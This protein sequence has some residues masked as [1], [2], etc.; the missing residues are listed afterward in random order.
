MIAL[1]T[2]S[3]AILLYFRAKSKGFPQEDALNALIY[4]VLGMAV[5]SKLLYIV[6]Y[7]PQ[8][9]SQLDTIKADPL[10]LIE[11]LSSGFVFYGGLI[12]GIGAVLA[13]AH[14]YQVPKL[15]LVNVLTPVIPFIHG[16]GRIGCFLA[17][18]C[19]GIP[20][21]GPLSVVYTQSIAAPRNIAMFPVQLLESLLLFLLAFFLLSYDR[22]AKNPRNLGGWYLLL[23]GVIRL[24]TELF[25]GDISRGFFMMLSTSQWISLMM[26]AVAAVL[27]YKKP[28]LLSTDQTV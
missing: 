12:G 27:L 6:Q 25:R 8:I 19:Y 10:S 17:G 2:L 16:F 21:D 13:Y 26:I 24:V 5:G 18:C 11:L 4:G 14:K 7:L 3:G 28:E 9:I 20:Y 23:Y 1:G 15:E 22:L